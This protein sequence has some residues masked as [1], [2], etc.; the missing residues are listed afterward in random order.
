MKGNYRNGKLYG[1]YTKWYEKGQ[2]DSEINFMNGKLVGISIWWNK[3]S[4][5]IR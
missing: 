1:K 4:Q 3:R 5:K 2:E